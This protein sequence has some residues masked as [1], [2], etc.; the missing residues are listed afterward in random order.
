MKKRFIVANW[1]M[2][3]NIAESVDLA[4]EMVRLWAGQGATK[5]DVVVALCPSH[6]SLSAVHTIVN[7]T[8]L[9]M[10]AQDVFWEDK[11][12]FTGEIAPAT[13]KE[14]GCEYCIVGHSE[15]RGFL[16]ENDEMVRRKVAALLRHNIHP[17]VCVGETMEERRA[18][19][20]DA[21]GINQV[22]DALK[23]NRPFGSQRI[24]IAYEPRWVIGSGQ[25]VAPEDAASMHQLIK[26]TLYD[27]LPADVVDSQIPIIY[28]GSVDS[29]NLA[30][31]L[32]VDVIHG[33]LVGGASLKAQE[34]IKLAEITA[35][36]V[37]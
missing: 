33:V 28:G 16:G 10:G 15:R 7:G 27:L 18:G 9:A 35:D 37:K 20:R 11:G 13:L 1:K 26:E 32:A 4:K 21:V 6:V 14:L 8:P 22:R 36:T 2:Q 30:G 19:K 31:F 3:L 34:F 23:D 5:P 25:A 29:N 24:V 17:I 12:A